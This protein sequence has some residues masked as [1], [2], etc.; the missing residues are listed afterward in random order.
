M[1]RQKLAD[2]EYDEL[3]GETDK[4]YQFSIG[5]ESVWIPKSI[6]EVDEESSTVT[7]PYNFAYEKGLI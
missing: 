1:P 2:I 5:N 6:A 4:A 7:V 3:L